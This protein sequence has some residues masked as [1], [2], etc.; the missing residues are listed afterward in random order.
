[1]AARLGRA[2]DVTASEVYFVD[3]ATMKFVQVNRAAREALGYSE[4]E[5]LTM[6]PF[7]IAP[8]STTTWCWRRLAPL[9]RGEVSE[10]VR[11]SAH[12]RKDGR[13]YP[14]EL[15][16]QLSRVDGEDLFICIAQDISAR[17]AAEEALRESRTQLT[18]A[19]RG[20][21]LGTW[22]SDLRTH[23][24]HYDWRTANMVGHDLAGDVPN[25]VWGALVHPDDRE[26]VLR[27]WVAHLKGET[28]YYEND[29]RVLRPDGEWRWLRSRG[30]IL[31]RDANGRGVRA[32]GTYLDIT[33]ERRSEQAL[34][35]SEADLTALF[36]SLSDSIIVL[37]P[38]GRVL[39]CNRAATAAFAEHYGT[40]LAEGEL[41]T[42]RLDAQAVSVMHA[43]LARAFA[44]GGAV[45]ERAARTPGGPHWFEFNYTPVHLADGSLRGVALLLRDIHERRQADREMLQAQKLE[46][47][48]V[49]AGGI[50]H[51]FNNLL[52]G[53]L[54]NAGLALARAAARVARARNTSRTSR[55]R[56]QRAADLARQM[57]AYA[58]KG[59]FVV[60]PLDS[61]RAR[62]R[63]GALLR[64]SIGKKARA[65]PRSRA[66][67]CRRRGGRDADPPGRHEPRRQRRATPS[68]TRGRDHA[69]HRRRARR[70]RR[71]SP[72][73]SLAPDL[74]EGDYVFLEVADTGAGMD[75][76]T[77]AASSTPSSRP[78][79]PG[80]GSGSPPCWASCAA[81]RGAHR[82][83]EPPRRGHHLSRCC[84]RPARRRQRP[85][86]SG[87]SPTPGA[88]TAP[89]S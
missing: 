57:L 53:I 73:V 71:T 43:D 41:L 56:G 6:G 21:D 3:P 16:I 80:A 49:L 29:F 23:T 69:H 37:D 27:V 26:D 68:A 58:G 20:A 85:W 39:R 55:P 81:H 17:R 63:D 62:R 35:E 52:V 34:A 74:P 12:R 45:F 1:M 61:Q 14:I 30:R 75:E 7:D 76:A 9:L 32:A 50:A 88:A 78:S 10:Q 5:L 79:S 87:P 2:L 47:L 59:R 8:G 67:T 44:E 51:D 4:A 82:R 64:V 22:D 36:A 77:L 28:Q 13:V 18:M 40:P 65:A 48:G 33:P 89:C 46:S 19:V 72:R 86:R 38:E 15:R 54:G 70:P 31:E 42:G 83:G 24:T 25:T 11:E 84:C 66:P 60:Q